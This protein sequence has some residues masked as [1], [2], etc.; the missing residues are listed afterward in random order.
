MS[1][2]LRLV[3]RSSR[4]V[5]P[6]ADPR[7]DQEDERD[8]RSVHGP[9]LVSECWPVNAGDRLRLDDVCGRDVRGRVRVAV[10]AA[11]ELIE[12]PALGRIS[13]RNV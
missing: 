10:H 1:G 6:D 7:H 4:R 9:M 11:A 5:P 12:Q 2:A 8:A 13:R 3:V